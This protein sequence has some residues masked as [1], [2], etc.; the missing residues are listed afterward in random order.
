MTVMAETT[1]DALA[2]LI[3]KEQLAEIRYRLKQPPERSCY[4]HFKRVRLE[5]ESSLLALQIAQNECA[6]RS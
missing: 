5:A 4:E 3:K 2:L 1:W 6:L